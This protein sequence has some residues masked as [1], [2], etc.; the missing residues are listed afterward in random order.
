MPTR[1]R[2]TI[3]HIGRAPRA[4]AGIGAFAVLVALAAAVVAAPRPA[5]LPSGQAVSA[6]SRQPSSD[7]RIPS[8][9]D[10]GFDVLHYDLELTLDPTAQRIDGRVGVHLRALAPL[11]EVRLD[12]VDELAVAAIHWNGTTAAFVHESD[13]LRISLPAALAAGGEGELAIDYG[14]RPPRHGPFLAGLLFRQHGDEPGSSGPIVPAIASISE[15]YSSHAWWPCKDHPHDKATATIAVTVPDT[16]AVVANGALVSRAAVGGGR[17]RWVWDERAPIATY[18]LAVAA[19]NYASWT[20]S[21]RCADGP[22]RLDYHAFPADSAAAAVDLAPTCAMLE[23]LCGVCGPY[24]FADE[25]YAQVEVVTGIAGMENQ[26]ATAIARYVLTGDGTWE[27]LVVHELAHSWFGNSLTPALWRDIWLNEGFAR[28]AE[29]LWAEHRHGPAGYRAF[30]RSIGPERWPDLFVGDGLLGDPTPPVLSALSYLVYDKG[31]WLLHMLRGY[32][33]DDRF[34][35][36]LRT[37]A[38]SPALKYGTTSTADFVRIASLEAGEDVGRFVTPWL[39]SD[40]VPILAITTRTRRAGEGTRVEVRVDQRQQPLFVLRLPLRVTTDTGPVDLSLP[41]ERRSTK[42]SWTVAGRVDRIEID[43]DGWLLY[44]SAEDPP[45]LLT[46]LPLAPNP[47]TDGHA[48]DL[49]WFLRA[50]AA[51]RVDLYDVRGRRLASWNLGECLATGAPEDGAEPARWVMPLAS[52][53]GGRRPAAGVYWV[54]VVTEGARALRK[55][56]LLH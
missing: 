17:E 20:E 47:A 8:P 12:L 44:R 56:T 33:G 43:P 34:F 35:A 2:W 6:A 39:T 5:P 25:K 52:V 51:L 18:L 40:A 42:G 3:V 24:P 46:L 16:L 28:Y 41:L 13:S 32:L 10:R 19:S 55:L 48:V 54:E 26:T 53:A 22:V 49:R 7:Y 45:P 9:D 23:F 36:A 11:T 1:D 27:S 30:M 15:P 50:P 14:G 4:Y 38:D 21:C 37:Y 29:A 31:A